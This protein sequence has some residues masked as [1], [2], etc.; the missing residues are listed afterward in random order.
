[1]EWNASTHPPVRSMGSTPSRRT[2]SR[3]TLSRLTLSTHFAVVV[4]PPHRP[5][6]R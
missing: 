3:L 6:P 2:P 1:M 5:V 4:P